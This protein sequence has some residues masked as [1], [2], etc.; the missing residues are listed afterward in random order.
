MSFARITRNQNSLYI[1][2]FAAEA[3][4]QSLHVRSTT[5]FLSLGGAPALLP[6][7]SLEIHLRK[8]GGRLHGSQVRSNS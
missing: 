4:E 8:C 2:R 3:L 7:T 1:E 6:A 5:P